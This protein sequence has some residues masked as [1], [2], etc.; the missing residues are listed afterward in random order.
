MPVHEQEAKYAAIS[1]QYGAPAYHS[2]QDL[3]T[4]MC[5]NCR[6]LGHQAARCPAPRATRR[7]LPDKSHPHTA[8]MS[9]LEGSLVQC[10]AIEAHVAGV[11]TVDT[12]PDS[13]SKITILTEDLVPSSALPHGTKPPISV[14]GGGTVMPAG[15]MSTCISLGPISA[16]V[17]V[18]VLPRNS[19][20]LI[21]GEDW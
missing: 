17:D 18:T 19:L 13:G 8:A 1:T 21:L 14:V 9:C 16:I 10:A 6:Q 11:G 5:F 7:R 20:P 2:V 12:F 3:N 4:A 15:T